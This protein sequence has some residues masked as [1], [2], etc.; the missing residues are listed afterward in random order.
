M[1][2]YIVVPSY[3][4]IK[5]KFRHPVRTYLV[6]LVLGCMLAFAILRSVI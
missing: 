2:R 4:D 1:A 3:P 6:L 5:H